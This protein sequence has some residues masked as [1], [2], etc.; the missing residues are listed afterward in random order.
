M[1]YS[2]DYCLLDLYD[3][4][5]KAY[6][7]LKAAASELI[8]VQ[9]HVKKT[10]AFATEAAKFKGKFKDVPKI[11]SS[12]PSASDKTP[13][14]APK[15]TPAKTSTKAPVSFMGAGDQQGLHRDCSAL[16]QSPVDIDTKTVVDPSA[17]SRALV[18]P[19]AFRYMSLLDGAH[20]SARLQLSTLGFC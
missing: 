7:D 9:A 17:I 15:K 5:L 11:S 6:N 19:L 4:T 8:S 13:T 18:Q 16:R 10:Q 12:A 2:N 3:D 20:D 14:K 1:F